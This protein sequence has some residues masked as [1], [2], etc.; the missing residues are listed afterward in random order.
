M[1]S[2]VTAKKC[3]GPLASFVTDGNKIL[4]IVDLQSGALLKAPLDFLHTLHVQVK[5]MMMAIGDQERSILAAAVESGSTDV[6][7]SVWSAIER[8]PKEEVRNRTILINL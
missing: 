1:V 3:C 5:T 8:Y 6:F 4:R 2:W 7:E